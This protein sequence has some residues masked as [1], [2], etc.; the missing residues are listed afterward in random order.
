MYY[1]CVMYFVGSLYGA[2]QVVSSPVIVSTVLTCGQ[3]LT[4][5]SFMLYFQSDCLVAIQQLVSG[6]EFNNVMIMLLQGK[7]SD[8]YGRRNIIL[9]SY[10]APCVGY[11]MMSRADSVLLLV[12]SRILPG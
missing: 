10:L 8:V 6:F 2:L 9:V 3:F 1:T 7:L 12:L 4:S 5:F 11:F